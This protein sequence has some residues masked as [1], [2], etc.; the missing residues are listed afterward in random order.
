MPRHS[1]T[2][3]TRDRMTWIQ[4]SGNQ[5]DIQKHS[6]SHI[7]SAL[8]RDQM[9]VMLVRRQRSSCE[10]REEEL[11]EHSSWQRTLSRPVMMVSGSWVE[12]PSCFQT[13]FLLPTSASSFYPVLKNGFRVSWRVTRP[14]AKPNCCKKRLLMSHEDSHTHTWSLLSSMYYL[15]QLFQVLVL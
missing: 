14:R 1:W 10:G 15:D 8:V 9:T 3:G 2:R 6:E 11:N 7:Y 12:P 4:Y 5:D 13:L